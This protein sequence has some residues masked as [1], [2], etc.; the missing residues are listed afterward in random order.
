M[1]CSF[2]ATASLT[3]GLL[4]AA[5]GGNPII[6]DSPPEAPGSFTAELTPSHEALLR[7][8]APAPSPDRAPVTGYR[9]YLESTDGLISALGDTQSLSYRHTGLLSGI[10]H[11]F[12]VRA[13]SGAGLSE[14][15][16]SAFVD[17]PPEPMLPPEAPGSL[18]AELTPSHEALLRWTAPASSPDRA[19]VTGY[20]VYLE[21]TDGLISALGDTQSLSY[22]HTG[23]LSG[24]RYVFH[25]RALSG[26]GLS[27]PSAS[28]FVDVPP[29]PVL[30]PEAPGSFTAELTPSHEALLRWTAPAPSPD[31]APVTGYR[32]YLESTDGLVSALGDTQSLSYRHTGLLSGIRYVFHV[33]ALS[34]AGLLSEPSAS[35]FVDV[36]TIL[37]PEAPG[38][39]SAELTP[40][41]EALLR[42]TAPAP[43]P[44]RAPVTGYRVYLESTDGLISALG[45]TQ[46]LSYRHTGLLSGIRYVF[47]VR[48]LSGAG[49][50]SE[51]SASAFVDVPTILPPEAPGSFS[52]ELTP[53]NEALLRWTAPAPSPN[54]APVTDYLIYLDSAGGLAAQIGTTQSLS[55]RHTGL[56]PGTRYVFHVRADSQEGASLPSAS[57]SVDVP[58]L[59]IAPVAAPHI[60]VRADL[61]DRSVV[62]SWVHRL[63]P[64]LP[65]VVTGFE[66]QYCEVPNAHTTDNCPNGA[67]T[68]LTSPL[69][70]TQREYIDE[71]FNADACDNTNARMYRV[72]ALAS[73]S[74]AS[75]RYSE[76]TRP[77]C[78][79]ANYSPPRRVE[80]LFAE[81]TPALRVNICWDVPE[82][83]R[84]EVIGYEL[85]ISPDENRPVPEDGWLILDAHVS[86]EGSPV[87][88]FYSGLAEDDE[89]W[90]R[91]RAYNLAGYGHWSVPYHYV[92]E[93]SYVPQSRRASAQSAATLSV[94]DAR[95]D[96]GPGATLAF[97]VTLSRA[98][99][100]TVTVDYATA[101]GTATVGQDYEGASGTLVFS[102]G[103]TQKKVHISVLDDAH[104]EDEET[105]TLNLSNASGTVIV[106]G[107][108]TGTIVNSDPLPKAWLSR[109]GRA[110]G[111]HVLEA[112]SYRFEEAPGRQMRVR[113]IQLD[114]SDNPEALAVNG[115]R[116]MT[117]RELMLGSAFHL[118]SGRN[119]GPA[120]SAWGRVETGGMEGEEDAA[121]LEGDIT[122]GLLGVDVEADRIVAGV[123]VSMS[124]GNGGYR[125]TPEGESAQRR[126]DMESSLAGVFPYAGLRV[127][128][129]LS[130]W[131]LVGY[132][133]GDLTLTPEGARP[134][135]TDIELRMGALGLRGMLLDAAQSNGVGLSVKSDAM[136][137]RTQ[138]ETVE[139]M[140]GTEA[141]VSRL[142]LALE[143]SR[144]MAL[145]SGATFTPSAEF[146]VRYDGGDAE[147][148]TGLE[149]GAGVRYASG[150][151]SIEGAVRGVLAH[152][153]SGY[154]EWVA[155]GSIRLAPETS[156]RGLSL[157]VAPAWGS[158]SNGARRLWSARYASEIAAHDATETGLRLDAEMGYGLR[159]PAGIGVASPY[160]A[161]SLSYGGVHT[162]RL[163]TRWNVSPGANL[164]AEVSRSVGNEVPAD[165][166][167]LRAAVHW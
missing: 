150:A 8:T 18:T 69:K 50:L 153:Q 65:T 134:I 14:P 106:D 133:T 130:L 31:R 120:L 114:A 92:H 54:R 43:S 155:S 87:C 124:E 86:P 55:Y 38:S 36:P 75:S 4:I 111:S 34:G 115:W 46:S 101:D 139:G 110:I 138:S 25:V 26:A 42:W 125:S 79:S 12:H 117:M 22:R 15:S 105:L 49:L 2:R 156:G 95:A 152:R 127:G 140:E 52:A 122:T 160:T 33:R 47:H 77:I 62:V 83:N 20:R 19:P 96:E 74:S 48:A 63:E 100:S 81:T 66:V 145:A 32:V 108:A 161:L 136:W 91:V 51:P 121:R 85:Q 29:E 60:T 142:R 162:V 30:P 167:M 11:V 165:A 89:R 39:F 13:L 45:D 107:E 135:E 23:L 97:A 102:R 71:S 57:A 70:P 10:R 73:V 68:A 157:T 9:V 123:S 116:D 128:E 137:L 78:P 88:R 104:D 37:P 109:F 90:F 28:A 58:G 24:I 44:D 3:L 17:V 93:H 151:L 64:S 80:A 67:W 56:L 119:G 149:A 141:D 98:L 94:A 1:I 76:P 118:S 35:A 146:G 159:A 166:V 143:G 21:S 5:C 131:G 27:E 144:A 40:S 164:N 147:T 148:G 154:E 113:G 103:E 6:P 59:P 82:A 99:P 16:A 53:S 163:G 158:V 112:V 84:S 129:R 7:W 41:N 72:R 132:G 61:A 126:S